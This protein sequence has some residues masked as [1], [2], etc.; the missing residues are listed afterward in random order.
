MRVISCMW[1]HAL[2]FVWRCD[3]KSFEQLYYIG[4][5]CLYLALR[6]HVLPDMV[7]LVMFMV[8]TVLGVLRKV[9]GYHDITSCEMHCSTQ[10]KVQILGL[11]VR[12]E[13]CC[14]ENKDQQMFCSSML[15][16]GA[17]RPLMCV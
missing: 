9:R 14:L 17:T 12:S 8:T 5:V 15:R 2:V 7:S 3:L 4:L 11:C 16:V 10:R 6:V 13:L 1:Y